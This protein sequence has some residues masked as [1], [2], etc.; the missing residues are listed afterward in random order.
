M[1]ATPLRPPSREE[2][3]AFARRGDVLVASDFDG[4]LA[5]IVLDP[6]SA[7]PQPGTIE[8]LSAMAA[9]PGVSVAL[10]SGRDLATLRALTGIDES[11]PIVLIGSHGAE[12]STTLGSAASGGSALSDVERAA[13]DG[14]TAA[15]ETIAERLP[16]TRVEYKPAGVVLHTRG[17]DEADAER[18]TRAA[19]AV[20]DD[21]AGVHAMRGKAVVEL[22]VLDVSK[23]AALAAL[24]AERG[25]RATFYLGDDVTDETVFTTLRAGSDIGVK[26]GDGDTAATHRVSECTDVPP[27]LDA[28]LGAL[29]KTQRDAPRDDTPRDDAGE[30]AVSAPEAGR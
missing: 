17:M 16:A 13:L 23:G 3:G 25:L 8:A 6:A 14:A 21:I 26:V 2:L 30:G 9:L 7:R 24:A 12:I 1:T 22:S 15:L 18:A 28:L 11:S 19:L 10:A 5:P 20:P 29:T 4:V 27:L